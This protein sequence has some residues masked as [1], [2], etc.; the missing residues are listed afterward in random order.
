MC[1]AIGDQTQSSQN[2]SQIGSFPRAATSPDAPATQLQ[3][4]ETQKS[5]SSEP[6]NSNI[7]DPSDYEE[8]FDEFMNMNNRKVMFNPR[9]GRILITENDEPVS[10]VQR[11]GIYDEDFLRIPFQR[12][13]CE[14]IDHQKAWALSIC[15]DLL[16]D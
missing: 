11:D 3:R 6:S 8:L 7:E 4:N 14:S 1:A 5:N 16:G 12:L 10:E 2:N 15:N 9:S 13:D